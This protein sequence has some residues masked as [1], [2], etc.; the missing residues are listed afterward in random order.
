[1]P[2]YSIRAQ[3][4]V[5]PQAGGEGAASSAEVFIYGD[6]GESWWDETIT[7]RDFVRDI[8]ALDVQ[9]LTVRI[10]SVGGSVPD[11]LAIYN[12]L[13]RHPASVTVAIDGMA[14]SIAS[15]IAMAG[16]RV[17]MAENAL[18]MI[19]APWTYAAGNSADMRETADLLDKWAAAMATSYAAKTGKAQADV[20]ALLTDGVDHFYTAA[21][22][23][24][25]GFVDAVVSAL[26]MAASG[27]VPAAALAR[28]RLP[29][30]STPAA[31][32]ASAASA[33]SAFLT[34]PSSRKETTTMPG[35][36]PSPPASP[37]AAAPSAAIA[38]PAPIV[39]SAA[40]ILAA[41]KARRE[42]IRAAAGKFATL[43]GVSAMMQA[44]EDELECS[45]DQA[46]SRLL[47]HLGAQGAPVAGGHVTTVEDETDKKRR[48]AVSALLVRAGVADAETVRAN[49]GNPYRGHKLL[50]LA[51]D[52]LARAGV[53]TDGMDQRQIVAAAFTQSTSDF[54]VLL[55]NAMHKT[56]LQ[57]YA[58]AADTWSRFCKIGSVSDFRAHPRYR[59]GSLGNL[60]ALSELGEFKNKAIP[61]GEKASIT[62]STKGNIINLSRQAVINDDLG[63]FVGLAQTFGRAARRTIEADVYALLALNGG[64]GPTMADGVTLFHASHNNIGTGAAISMESIDA[65]RVKM[66]S[67]KD[68]SGNDFLDIRPAVLL[69]PIGLGGTARSINDAQYDPDTANK[70]QKP[71]TVRGLYRD[72]VDT[73]R[74][75]GTRRYSFADPNDAPVI[76]VAFL[77][78]VQEPFLEVQNGFDVDGARYKVRLDF[79]VGATDFRGAVTNAGA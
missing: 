54:P 29:A 23:V 65:D 11:G 37:L 30:S 22:A 76:E 3:K 25:Q 50:D 71:N 77:D 61:D 47:A 42:G 9:S 66:A 64:L 49:A 46:K 27:A 8:A 5:P 10:N 19:H 72:I 38:A 51:R 13:K 41:D 31:S 60:D 35:T 67:Q 36:V 20:L 68:I 24:A 59:V 28:F 53:R 21:E 4:T 62:A 55:E 17:E 14:M 1:M 69:L 58:T 34:S 75:T 26:P 6:I 52:A 78:G 7:A 15:L 12:A 48:A 43:P 56:L 63:A 79:A 40:E 44:C 74:L 70:L 57:A 32:V 73:P 39:P 33:A 45:V 16:D 18:L 2:W